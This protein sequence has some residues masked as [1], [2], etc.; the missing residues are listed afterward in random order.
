M[1]RDKYGNYINEKDVRIKINTDPKGNGHISFYDGEVD[2][3]H[4]AVHINI[5]YEKESWSS[6]SHNEDKSESD[7]GS[8]G[9]YLTSACIKHFQENFDDNCEEL[10]I[11]RW[12]RDN[13]VSKQDVKHY[14]KIAPSIVKS[15][16]SSPNNNEI[17]NDIYTNLVVACVN[18]I[19]RG[20]YDF[21]YKQYKDSVLA[22]EKK[23][24][25]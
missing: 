13:Y 21:A 18:A 1:D 17:Y 15:I 12:F 9:C 6:P 5:N 4:S 20:E 22:L 16:D 7:H 23:F 11:L 14:Y 24:I 8:G 19:K 25:M 10:L 3:E 2:E